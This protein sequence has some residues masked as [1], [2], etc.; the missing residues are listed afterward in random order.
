MFGRSKGG[1]VKGKSKSR[2]TRAGPQF[3]VGRV[4]R[5][6]RKGILERYKI[7]EN[8]RYRYKIIEYQKDI[9]NL[10]IITADKK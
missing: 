6:L 8:N 5:L 10:K 2:S 9:K 7:I 3:P 1:K 4:H